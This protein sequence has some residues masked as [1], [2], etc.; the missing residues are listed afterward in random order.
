VA[1]TSGHQHLEGG[2]APL[3]SKKRGVVTDEEFHSRPAKRR[4]PQQLVDI[5]DDVYDKEEDEED[6]DEDS[7]R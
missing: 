6:I 4:R 5:E 1:G 2:A 3:P 7:S